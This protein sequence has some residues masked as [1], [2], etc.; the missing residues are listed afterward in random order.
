MPSSLKLLL[1]TVAIVD[2]M[3]AVAI[4]AVAY[5][6]SIHVLPLALRGRS[7]SLALYV[8]NRRGDARALWPYLVGFALLWLLVLMSGVHATIAGV[9]R[10]RC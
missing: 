8:C 1:T 7:R 4:I 2:D 5:T 10:P 9:R 6:A 3:G